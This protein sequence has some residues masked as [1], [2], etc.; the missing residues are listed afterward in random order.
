M[1]I[2]ES[3]T[4]ALATWSWK[5]LS[6][7]IKS[8]SQKSIHHKREIFPTTFNRSTKSAENNSKDG[9]N[10]F[11]SLHDKVKFYLMNAQ[12]TPNGAHIRFS[13]SFLDWQKRVTRA[14]LKIH[15][16]YSNENKTKLNST[17][18]EFVTIVSNYWVALQTSST[19]LINFLKVE[20]S[21]K[22]PQQSSIC[23]RS[24]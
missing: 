2:F 11:H 17:F 18:I 12:I 8:S 5:C 24:D 4:Y 23:I 1:W 15:R 10:L 21:W 7:V 9:G 19:R 6:C 16:L 14:E 22:I 13:N 20:W 3:A